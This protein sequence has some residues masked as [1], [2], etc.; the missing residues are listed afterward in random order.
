M[1]VIEGPLYGHTFLYFLLAVLMPVATLAIAA[2][3]RPREF[4]LLGNAGVLLQ[5]LLMNIHG[6][7]FGEYGFAYVLS[8][9][10]FVTVSLIAAVPFAKV[11]EERERLA[12]SS[13]PK[14][15]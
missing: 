14:S 9:F 3:E 4:A 5:L 15:L 6:P 10:G 1:Y 11:I 8:A 7:N 2:T 12:F 13:S